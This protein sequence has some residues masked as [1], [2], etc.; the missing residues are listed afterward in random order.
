MV[1]AAGHP[2]TFTTTLN[3]SEGGCAV[4]W[5]GQPPTVGGDVC[6]RLGANARAP[7]AHFTVRW[8]DSSRPGRVGLELASDTSSSLAWGRLIKSV[9]HSSRP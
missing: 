7:E 2:G 8:V 6:L 9:G 3:V 1:V 5:P 4:R